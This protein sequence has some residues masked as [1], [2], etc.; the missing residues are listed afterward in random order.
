MGQDMASQCD[1][2]SSMA[3]VTMHF[4]LESIQHEA[5]KKAAAEHNGS[6][7][8]ELRRAIDRYLTDLMRLR[9]AREKRAQRT[10]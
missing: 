3:K 8:A 4:C 6:V 9:D 2:I 1:T 7:S 5:L 10:S